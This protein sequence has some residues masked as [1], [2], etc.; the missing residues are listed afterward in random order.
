MERSTAFGV[1][2]STV[3]RSGIDESAGSRAGWGG[4]GK[5]STVRFEF[6]AAFTPV[7]TLSLEAPDR[8]SGRVADLMAT[9]AGGFWVADPEIGAL[10]VHAPDGTLVRALGRE[11]TSL[12]RPVS[13]TG[14]HGHWIVALDG[15]KPRLAV[16]DEAGRL[17]RRFPLPEVDRPVQVCNLGDRW[18]AVAG[19]GWRAGAG[20]LIHLYTPFGDHEDS[21]FAVPMGRRGGGR[22]YVASYGTSIYLAHTRSEVVSIYDILSRT[23]IAFPTWA[24]E[25]D[26]I[27]SSGSLPRRAGGGRGGELAGLFATRCGEALTM[28]RTEGSDGG[29]VYD[30]H[31]LNGRPVARGLWAEE[32]VVGLEGPFFYSVAASMG[33]VQRGSVPLR[34]WK[35]SYPG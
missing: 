27:S 1:G 6:G 20:K 16:L 19:D 8:G 23:V 28:Y 21:L 4:S 35:L 32:R 22:A 11:D 30:L 9:R 15:R 18:L 24:E 29:F 2:G 12:S 17:Q 14:L 31:A 13:L 7:R 26:A 33:S 34:I 5:P 3:G 25:E 10:R